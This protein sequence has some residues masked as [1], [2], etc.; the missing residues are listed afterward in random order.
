MLTLKEHFKFL[1]KEIQD[2]APADAEFGRF[3]F[4]PTR[5]DTPSPK[6]PNTPSEQVALKALQ[7]YFNDNNKGPLSSVAPLLLKLHQQGYYEKVLSPED[8]SKVYRFLRMPRDSFVKLI[9]LDAGKLQK[10]GTVGGGTLSPHESD[11][12]GWTTNLGLFVDDDFDGYG[13]GDVVGIFAANV[14]ENNFFGN[15]GVLAQSIGEMSFVHEME[16]IAVGPVKYSSCLYAI[17]D[18]YEMDD[19]DLLRDRIR[20]MFRKGKGR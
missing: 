14:A 19:D 3:I 11:I 17:L 16:T 20:K 4:A 7:A 15:P 8:F 1:L 2:E 13:D 6:E 10:Q 18:S 5:A 9:G 12:S